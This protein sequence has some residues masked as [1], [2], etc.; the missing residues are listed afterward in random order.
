V[1]TPGT[2]SQE[3][4][5][6]VYPGEGVNGPGPLK[7]TRHLFLK[8]FNGHIRIYIREGKHYLF[9]LKK[10]LHDKVLRA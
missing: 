9:S 8:K 6:F 5:I 2:S 10:V 1:Y 7:S 3:S 4:N